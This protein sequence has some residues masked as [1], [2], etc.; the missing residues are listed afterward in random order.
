L[1]DAR[2]AAARGNAGVAARSRAAHPPGR[3]GRA[4]RNRQQTVATIV[5]AAADL[6]ARKGPDGFGLAE[7]GSN[8]GVSFGLIHRYFGGK[9]GLLKEALRQPF[10]RQLAALLERYENDAASPRRVRRAPRA[11]AAARRRDAP[12]PSGGGRREPL[13]ALLF[14][15]QRRNPAYVRLIA[16]G[17]L[18]GLL[19]ADLFAEDRGTIER[20][21]ALY[22]RSVRLPREVDARAVS[23]LLLIATLGFELFRPLVQ[24]LFDVG[25]DF[26]AVYREHLRTALRAF[27]GGDAR[28]APAGGRRRARVPGA[29]AGARPR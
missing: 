6:I 10:T 20:L 29:R 1:P 3:R 16:W 7:L 14:E 2:G 17:I 5:A 18:T 11:G 27:R 24:A 25:D 28:R 21:L 23:A 13:L 12:V 22:R 4:P 9:E 26:D 15:A 19:S 8:A